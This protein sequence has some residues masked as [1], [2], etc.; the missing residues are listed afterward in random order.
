MTQAN[1]MPR[2]AREVSAVC[3]IFVRSIVYKSFY[4]LTYLLVS[5]SAREKTVSRDARNTTN[6][7]NRQSEWGNPPPG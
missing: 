1:D 6:G 3:D 5:C 4:L 7:E 2:V